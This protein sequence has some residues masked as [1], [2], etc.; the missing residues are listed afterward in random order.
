MLDPV[1]FNLLK[2]Y[3]YT[4]AAFIIKEL[5]FI[6]ALLFFLD[7]LDFV[8]IY[9]IRKFIILFSFIFIIIYIYTDDIT[10]LYLFSLRD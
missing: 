6:K 3:Y 7:I 8:L 4:I 2:Y 5:G 10:L 9:I 1:L